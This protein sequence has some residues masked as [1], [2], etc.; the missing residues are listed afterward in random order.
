MLITA[1]NPEWEDEMALFP[2]HDSFQMKIG[3][4]KLDVIWRQRS[5]D[6]FLGLP[7]NIASY[8]LLLHLAAKEL[9]VGEGILTGHLGDTHL[10]ENHFEQVREQLRRVPYSLPK[11]ETPNFTSIF[12]WNN[13]QT[14]IV[15][16]TY[17]H[18]SKI[19]APVAV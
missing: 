2:C 17:S 3:D 4:N 12:D 14:K 10:Y 5:V 1:V 15:P 19:P 11:I 8:G 7:F 16:G 9:N 13:T 6:T 18:Y